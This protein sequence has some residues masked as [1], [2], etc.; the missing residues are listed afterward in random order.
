MSRY[1]LTEFEWRVI[2]PLLPNKPC[3]L[4]LVADQRVVNGIF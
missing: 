3:G 2:S 1:D 4:A